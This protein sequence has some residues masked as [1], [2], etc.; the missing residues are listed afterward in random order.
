MKLLC[1]LCLLLLP[2]WS[3]LAHSNQA[4]L[5]ATRSD[6]ASLKTALDAFKVDCGRF[7]STA[8][9]WDVLIQCPTNRLPA[10]WLGPYLCNV[11]IDPWGKP[12]VYACPGRHN[13]NGFDLYSCGADGVSKTQGSDLDDINNWDNASPHGGNYFEEER[14]VSINGIFWGNLA[15]FALVVGLNSRNHAPKV[16]RLLYR[17]QWEGMLA[18]LWFSLGVG[19]AI[20]WPESSTKPGATFILTAVFA[21]CLWWV[22]GLV[23]AI[24]GMRSCSAIGVLSGSLAFVEFLVVVWWALTPKME[25]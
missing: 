19:L 1:C 16:K 24:S 2:D 7:P 6:M 8:E 3:A 12:Y 23:L 14:P 17:R 22:F 21:L 25:G 20:C 4:R 5:P 15:W 10:H 18:M 13:T 11:P 9:G